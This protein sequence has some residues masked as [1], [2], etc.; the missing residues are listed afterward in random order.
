MAEGLGLGVGGGGRGEGGLHVGGGGGGGEEVDFL[1]DGAAE[2]VEGFADVGRVVVGFVG[3]LGAGGEE[4]VE[5][6][7]VRGSG[8]EGGCV[9][10]LEEL[11]VDL[12]EG[13]DALLE[14]DV[15]RGKFCLWMVSDGLMVSG[16]GPAHLVVDLTELLFEI[17]L[18]SACERADRAP[19]EEAQVNRVARRYASTRP[20]YVMFLPKAWNLSMFT[21]VGGVLSFKYL[22]ML[23]YVDGRMIGF[24]CPKAGNLDVLYCSIVNFWGYGT[25]SPRRC[26][27]SDP[28]SPS[29]C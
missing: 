14:G 10:D 13:V 6:G 8:G 18:C 7:G 19:T 17:L 28:Q 20:T 25:D 1:G 5:I 29:M 26:C 3:V 27:S 15:V 23:C 9:R 22:R 4:S 21:S 24:S 2:V 12:F 16:W 11:L